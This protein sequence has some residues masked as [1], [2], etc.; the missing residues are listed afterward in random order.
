MSRA[1]DESPEEWSVLAHDCVEG[2]GAVRPEE[3]F[4][5]GH[6]EIRAHPLVPPGAAREEI[7]VD[8]VGLVMRGK[9]KFRT[10]YV[11]PPALIPLPPPLPPL[12]SSCCGL[13][14]LHLMVTFGD[15]NLQRR[16]SAITVPC[17]N[18]GQKK[19]GDYNHN[20]HAELLQSV[21]ITGNGH[22]M[23]ISRQR[24]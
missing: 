18:L 11:S 23:M 19:T 6:S 13:A 9:E 22:M 8:T 16:S 21:M 14:W 20:L 12:G 2:R 4:G 7:V 3:G 15:E 17:A 5:V 1:H 10:L 24:R